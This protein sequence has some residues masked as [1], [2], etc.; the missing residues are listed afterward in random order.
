MRG[1]RNIAELHYVDRMKHVVDIIR[2]AC[3][4]PDE[5]YIMVLPK[6]IFPL[7]DLGK[8]CLFNVVSDSLLVELW[9]QVIPQLA[10]RSDGIILTP[11]NLPHT[12]KKN[13][14]MFKHKCP[15]DHTIDLQLGAR[16]N[17]CKGGVEGM[18]DSVD[19]LGPPHRAY[20]LQTWDTQERHDFCEV[21]MSPARWAS[22]GIPDPDSA[23]GVILGKNLYLFLRQAKKCR[24]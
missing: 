7:R 11:N 19:G 20:S 18:S 22:I 4:P 9:T 3:F 10:H 23:A 24:M 5:E 14:L 15:D 1:K 8:V 2:W 17:Y 13:K 6:Q 16:L 12:G 21:S